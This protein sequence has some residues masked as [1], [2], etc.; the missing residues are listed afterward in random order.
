MEYFWEGEREANEVEFLDFK[1]MDVYI[2]NSKISGKEIFTGR[3][4][5]KGEF[6]LKISR[7]YFKVEEESRKKSERV[8]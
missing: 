4:F 6:V 8:E 7:N 1:K 3:D 2:F 5:K